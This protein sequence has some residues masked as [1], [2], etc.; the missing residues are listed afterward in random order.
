VE[1]QNKTSPDFQSLP[2]D[3]QMRTKSSQPLSPKSPLS[4][5]LDVFHSFDSQGEKKKLLSQNRKR[6]YFPQLGMAVH[7]F[8]PSTQEVDLCNFEASLVYIV[9]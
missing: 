3:H 1:K 7:A 8:N 9:N 4:L 6:K 2:K 5:S